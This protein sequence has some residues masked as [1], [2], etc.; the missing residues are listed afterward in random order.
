MRPD[1]DRKPLPR[2]GVIRHSVGRSWLC[3][4]LG[5]ASG[6]P[7][8]GA[9]TDYGFIEGTRH[10]WVRGP[11]D[12][13]QPSRDIDEVIDQLCPAIMELPGTRFGEHGQEYCGAIYS[14][15]DGLYRSSLPSP[16]GNGEWRGPQKRK[17][18]RP[19]LS[20]RDARGRTSVSADYHGH[21][22]PN[23]PMSDVDRQASTQLW[24]IRIQFD[25]TCHIQKLIP[26]MNENRPGE[27]Y[28]RQG[29]TWKLIGLIQPA[30]KAAGTVEDP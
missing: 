16:L 17:S 30:D 15:G 21:P 22:W 12:A 7:S 25:S 23:S 4:V 26:Y 6:P 8:A 1:S 10:V 29:K 28:E 24:H 19:P 11:W 27:L 20:V 3:V 14:L 18:C 5:C 13:I 9:T 2:T